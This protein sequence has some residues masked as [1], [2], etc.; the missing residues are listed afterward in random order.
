ERI[1][2]NFAG[3]EH[4]LIPRVFRELTTSMVI[5]LE[6]I[7]GMKITDFAALDAAGLDRDEIARRAT[8]MLV[9]MVF[10][11][12][13]FH[14]DPHPGNFLITETGRIGLLDFG[15]VGV[16]D[17][18]LRE[19]MRRLFVRTLQRDPDGLARLLIT[20]GVGDG[21]DRGQLRHD[22]A[23]L[24]QR[25]APPGGDLVVAGLVADLL[26]V[27]RRHH[28]RVPRDLALLLIAIVMEEAI[29]A[30][31]APDF[32]VGEVLAPYARR[33]VASELSPAA[34]AR[35]VEDLGVDLATLATDLPQLIRNV[36][37]VIGGG[38]IEV[39]IRAEETHALLA[40]AERLS[41]RLAA[42]AIFGAVIVAGSQLVAADRVLGRS[43]PEIPRAAGLGMIGSAALYGAWRIGSSRLRRRTDA[44]QED[45]GTA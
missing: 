11:D 31:V 29:A 37:E 3:E 25:H 10:E 20:L 36:L 13:F 6:R 34:L 44:G 2:A 16:L 18:D 35:R 26:E 39:H 28:L 27:V 15:R 24:L 4:V 1:A 41:D 8:Q 33:L 12:G 5:T 38:S 21:V 22:I 14:A 23:V 30:E 40:R 7:R 19:Q 45:A 43:H 42:S 17:D 9:K 32:R